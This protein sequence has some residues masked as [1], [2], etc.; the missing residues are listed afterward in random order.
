MT[1]S[2]LKHG[3]GADAIALE[4]ELEVQLARVSECGASKAAVA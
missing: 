4:T 3:G 2:A 1:F